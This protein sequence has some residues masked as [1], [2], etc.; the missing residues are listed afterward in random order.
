M[1]ATEFKKYSFRKY[2]AIRPRHH[3]LMDIKL[4]FLFCNIFI[5]N[6][7]LDQG[8]NAILQIYYEQLGLDYV[9]N[10]WWIVF[11][12]ENIGKILCKQC[13]YIQGGDKLV[14]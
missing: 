13:T 12:F 5:L 3:N 6:A 8:K 14:K 9:F 1:K 4:Q 11:W 7:L 10:I 2:Y